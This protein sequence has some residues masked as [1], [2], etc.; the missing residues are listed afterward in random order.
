MRT[1]LVFL[2]LLSA[3]TFPRTQQFRPFGQTGREYV[4]SIEEFLAEASEIAVA[5]DSE[6]LLAT[7]KGT[8]TEREARVAE[9]T[10]RL[11]A[12]LRH[13]STLRR[14]TKLVGRYFD[15]VVAITKHAGSTHLSDPMARIVRDLAGLERA[16]SE[17]ATAADITAA[18][19]T[20][21]EAA[22]SGSLQISNFDHYPLEGELYSGAKTVERAL[23]LQAIAFRT[24]ADAVALDAGVLVRKQEQLHVA[25]AYGQAKELDDD[26]KD[27]RRRILG[28]TI[29]A[30]SAILASDTANAMRL[31]FIAVTEQRFTDAMATSI[32]RDCARL[33]RLS[34]RM[35]RA[36]VSG[37]APTE[38]PSPEA[39][40]KR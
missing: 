4:R 7:R 31:G 14:Q 11:L 26:W 15:G 36:A 1:F 5:A 9:H 6:T 10:E 33:Q 39:H 40:N 30:D 32:E 8:S 28:T 19:I 38:V 34:S 3:C 16:V 27:R 23:A 18:D 37:P 25:R 24:L 2:A 13:Y 21:A 12:R 35:S 29:A 22:V 17:G 20:A